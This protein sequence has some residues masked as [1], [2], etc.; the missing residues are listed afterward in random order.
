MVHV[1]KNGGKGEE[2]EGEERKEEG[3]ENEGG[4]RKREPGKGE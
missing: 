4:E 2:R 1:W 3:R